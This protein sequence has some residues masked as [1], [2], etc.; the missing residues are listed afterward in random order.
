MESLLAA[1]DVK[2]AS[3]SQHACICNY[4]LF[5]MP[6]KDLRMENFD[7][8]VFPQ[9]PLPATRQQHHYKISE[10]NQTP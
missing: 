6:V 9:Q 5:Q 4:N 10:E 3:M 2:E 8:V 1:A 7:A